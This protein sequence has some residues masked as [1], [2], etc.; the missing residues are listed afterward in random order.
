M[1][2]EQL[3][4]ALAILQ[5]IG[6]LLFAFLVSRWKNDIVD[7]MDKVKDWADNRF[8]HKDLCTQMHGE[9]LRMI[10]NIHKEC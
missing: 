8:V 7:S 5:T 3:A 9:T 1:R 6:M 10:R 4:V 2:L